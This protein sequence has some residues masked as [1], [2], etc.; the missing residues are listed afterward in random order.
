MNETISSIVVSEHDIKTE[1]IESLIH[2]IRGKQV[3]IDHD[4][5]ML[6]GVE[7]RVLNQAVK[8]NSERFPEDFM[9]Q[10]NKEEC[11][12]SQNVILN[13]KRGGNIK[14]LPYAFTENGIAMLSSVLRSPSAIAININIMRAF[15]SLRHFANANVEFLQRVETLEHHQLK[16]SLQLK[17]NEHKLEKI[18]K[19]L[20][21]ENGQKRQGIFFDGQIF[22]AYK[23]VCDLVREANA[24]IVLFDNYIDDSVLSI[25]DKRKS[26]VSAKIFTRTITPKLSLD[27]NRHNAQYP[28]IEVH[29][30]C[31][32]HDRFL[33][34]DDTVYHIGASLKDLG[35]KLFAF[36][37]M[38][39]KTS[40]LTKH[41]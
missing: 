17:N 24:S 29:T 23:F 20:D 36:A 40:E 39:I 25:L 30:V 13:S 3:M 28:P 21:G 22:D 9:F 15:S 2:I 38:E 33:C 19:L 34:I 10:L 5:A 41:I 14:Y 31:H 12:K 35:K 16:L 8:R 11:S 7:T 37:I 4:I 6:Y 32:F 1:N 18:F 26:V 27:I